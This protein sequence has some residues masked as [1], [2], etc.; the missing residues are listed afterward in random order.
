MKNGRIPLLNTILVYR[1]LHQLQNDRRL[2]TTTSRGTPCIWECNVARK[3]E[4]VT[5]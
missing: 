3:E 4:T 5:T 1:S 2:V